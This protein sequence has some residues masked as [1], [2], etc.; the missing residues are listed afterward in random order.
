MTSPKTLVVRRD[1]DVSVALAD[2]YAAADALI[3]ASRARATVRAYKGDW[4]RFAAWC[5][6]EAGIEPLDAHPDHVAAYVATLAERGY[7]PS[8][9]SRAIAS[10]TSAYTAAGRAHP[11]TKSDEVR[12]TLRGYRRRVGAR[13]RQARPL[14]V[15]EVSRM[16]GA[17]PD[18]LA[19]T[20]DRAL[21]LLGFAA[22][23]RRG[24]LSSLLVED[25]VEVDNGL[26]VTIRQSK[27]DQEGEG[28]VVPVGRA[29]D[30]QSCPVRAWQAWV[31]DADLTDGPAWR[32]ITRHGAIGSG[33][34]DRAITDILLRAA[35]RAGINTD[36]LSAHSL[37]AGYVTAAALSGASER[38]IA[39]VSRHKSVPVLR[40]YVRRATV[41]QDAAT[42]LGW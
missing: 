9:I 3:A 22:A 6:A 26:E 39:A 17:L 23:L 25:V 18:T 33:L 14:T 19:G 28:A 11:P 29:R 8:T 35:I 24:E 1:A 2:G 15:V 42:D 7:K 13:R 36:G 16:A 20:R 40:S 34:S 31:T 4:D 41:W 38:A 12:L 37:R 21:L 27:T 30:P 10:L 32:A 5:T